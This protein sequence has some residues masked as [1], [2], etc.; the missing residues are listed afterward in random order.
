MRAGS[1]SVGKFEFSPDGAYVAFVGEAVP[2]VPQLY[3]VDMRGDLPDPPRKVNEFG[4]V[5]DFAWSPDS[6]NIAYP[7]EG[8]QTLDVVITS[9]VT[10]PDAAGDRMGNPPQNVSALGFVTP[11]LLTYFSETIAFSPAQH[12]WPFQRARQPFDAGCSGCRR[13]GERAVR[14]VRRV[15]HG[16][17]LDAG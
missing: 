16:P 9:D 6:K 13:A 8:D 15:V 11:S 3:V 10:L 5:R 12:G 4:L 14:V 1:G 17:D 7:V 2:S